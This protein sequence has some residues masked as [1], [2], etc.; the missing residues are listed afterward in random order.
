MSNLGEGIREQAYEKGFKEGFE[1]SFK[2]SFEESYKKGFTEGNEKKGMRI[3]LNLIGI[4]MSREEAQRL[5]E[6]GDDLVEKAL[7]LQKS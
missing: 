1:K 6:I 3:F 7:N 4:G 2:K 5:A